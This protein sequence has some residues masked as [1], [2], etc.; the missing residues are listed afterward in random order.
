MRRALHHPNAPDASSACI[1][2]HLAICARCVASHAGAVVFNVGLL[3]LSEASLDGAVYQFAITSLGLAIGSTLLVV[4][5]R[6]WASTDDGEIDGSKIRRLTSRF[7]P[8]ATLPDSTRRSYGLFF[9]RRPV[10]KKPVEAVAV[11]AGVAATKG[12]SR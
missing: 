7:H 3:S 10:A 4:P 11:A 6:F 12:A 5:I 2:F 9:R 8:T 1:C